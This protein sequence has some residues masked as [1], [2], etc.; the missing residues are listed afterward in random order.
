MTRL[1]GITQSDILA[2]TVL[3]ISKFDSG[4][5]IKNQAIVI[6]KIAFVKG[7]ENKNPPSECTGPPSNV[8]QLPGTILGAVFQWQ[9]WGWCCCCCCCSSLCWWCLCCRFS[10]LCCCFSSVSSAIV[11]VIIIWVG[12]AELVRDKLE[13][14]HWTVSNQV[15]Y[16][17]QKIQEIQKLHK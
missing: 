1:I 16:P 9:S 4:S 7:S 14:E 6:V 17:E 10:S 11:P 5:A 12:P 3:L 13:I 15:Q 8:D 2:F